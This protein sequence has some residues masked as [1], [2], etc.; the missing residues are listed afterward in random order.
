M[1]EW[2]KD[3]SHPPTPFLSHFLG[4]GPVRDIHPTQSERISGWAGHEKPWLG[5]AKRHLFD[6]GAAWLMNDFETSH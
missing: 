3:G 1:N 2:R 5:S 4:P 6:I